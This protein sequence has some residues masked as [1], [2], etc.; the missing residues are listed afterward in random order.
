MCNNTEEKVTY[1]LLRDIWKNT[2]YVNH[3]TDESDEID[4]AIKDMV[5]KALDMMCRKEGIVSI[6]DEEIKNI[7]IM[8]EKLFKGKEKDISPETPMD[9]YNLGLRIGKKSAISTNYEKTKELLL[10]IKNM[11]NKWFSFLNFLSY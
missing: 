4:I 2:Q 6:L 1:E 10:F 7:S 9:Y 3:I 11:L 5:Q 8:Q